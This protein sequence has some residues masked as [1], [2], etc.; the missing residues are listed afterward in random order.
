RIDGRSAGVVKIA[1]GHVPQPGVQGLR[2]DLRLPGQWEDEES[3]LY[4]NDQR[5][6][7]P[8]A[9][10]YIS[11][12]PLGLEGGLNG[13]AYVGNNPLGYSDPLGLI[14]FA[15]DGTNNSDPPP[16]NDN[17][18][19]DDFSNVYK[20]Y[21][22]YDQDANGR[23]WYMNGVG[24]DDPDSGI[25]TN[26][27]DQYDANTARERV[28]FML[29]QLDRYMR[30]T[31]FSAG[32]RVDIDIVGFSRGSAMA[33]DFSNR[34]AQ[35]LR[36]NR[37]RNSGACVSIRFMGLWDTV[38]Q[39]GPNGADNRFWRLAIPPEARNV[40]HAVALNEHRYLFPGES[41]GRGTQRGFI[42]SHAD[43]GGSYG[44]GDLSDVALNWITEQAK[45]SGI[46]VK[47]WRDVGH[48]EWGEV[49]N[50]VLH[51]KSE[52]NRRAPE[53]RDFCLRVNNEA[54]A[55]NCQRQRQANVGGMSWRGTLNYI[56]YWK[57]TR[58]DADGVSPMVGQVNMEGYAKWLHDN[59]GLDIA[60]R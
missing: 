58:M 53:D 20:F 18:N 55:D 47:A 36:E 48:A 25:Q 16:T 11:P 19:Q 9:G 8:E 7:D 23:K 10:R 28:D 46:T 56:D 5:Y 39:F 15:F 12:D 59:Y 50:P 21:L 2:L 30:D 17:G 45:N 38:A 49:T 52:R 27:V 60:H 37:Y 42:G 44:T 3:G 32:Q 22:A 54:W 6:Y 1:A 34:V 41:I 33:R 31:R 13:Y 24:R 4:Y 29:G 26:R 51:D 14:L 57:T 35:R 40:F 43:V